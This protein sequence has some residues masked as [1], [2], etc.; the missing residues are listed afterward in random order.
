[1]ELSRAPIRCAP[2]SGRSSETVKLDAPLAM[3]DASSAILLT[4]AGIMDACCQVFRIKMTRRVFEE[5]T[6]MDRPGERRLRA[7]AGKASG[8]VV[9]EDP[10]GPFPD[11]AG[12]DLQRLHQG[13]R[14]TLHHFLNGTVRFV[15]L[16]D[17]KG[18]Q[19]CRRQGIPHI[20][21]LL[22]PKILYYCEWLPDAR[23]VRSAHARRRQ[24]RPW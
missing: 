1:M 23:Q 14:D 3:I 17:G 24:P 11:Q 20:N 9:V 2:S 18:V 13:E 7:L 8:F 6:V 5:V 10:T 22:C 16:D 21:A 19:V 15:I 4:K 12:A